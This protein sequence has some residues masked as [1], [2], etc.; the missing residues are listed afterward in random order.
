MVSYIRTSF[1]F[2]SESMYFEYSLHTN[3]LPFN[4]II[5]YD[6]LMLLFGRQIQLTRAS[7]LLYFILI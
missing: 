1:K 6:F 2:Y 7:T 3:V 4:G 5:L